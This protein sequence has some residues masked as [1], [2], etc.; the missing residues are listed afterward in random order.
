MFISLTRLPTF[1][2]EG[3]LFVVFL[4]MLGTGPG[5]GPRTPLQYVRSAVFPV[6]LADLSEPA[7]RLYPVI[8]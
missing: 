7:L 1:V 2:A 5:I 8:H 4:D 3:K 6:V